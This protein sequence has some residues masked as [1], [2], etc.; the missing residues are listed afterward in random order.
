MFVGDHELIELA[1]AGGFSVVWKARRQ[2]TGELRAIKLPRVESLLEH[3]RREAELSTLISDTQVVP[4]LETRLDD[5]TPHLVLPWVE[6]RTLALPD[7]PPPPPEIVA[8]FERALDLASVVARLHAAGIVHGDLKPGN[9]MV[10]PDGRCRLLDLGLAKLQVAARL[11]RSL[12]ES[13]VSVDGKSVAGTLDFMAPELYE[14]KGPSGASDVYG[15]GV[16]LHHLLTGR[17]PAFGVSPSSL[18]PYLPPGTEHLLRSMLHH[19]PERRAGI[20]EVARALE[21]LRDAERRCLARRNGH[22]RRRVFQARMTTLRR[23]LRGLSLGVAIVTP[24]LGLFFLSLW[25]L[26]RGEAQSLLAVGVLF[27][28]IGSSLPLIMAMTTINAWIL[29]IPEKTYKNRH[30]HPI[31]SFMMQ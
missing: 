28:V 2:G 30:G 3:L 5:E 31:W 23:G 20:D 14:G 6:G 10:G 9:V 16:L 4:I 1:G 18:N 19:D 8:A 24:L 7:A 22:E 13:L 29:R 12:E 27:L 21:G 15:L 17:P 26:P 25:G 11:E